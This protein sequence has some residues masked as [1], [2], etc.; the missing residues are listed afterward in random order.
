MFCFTL[1]YVTCWRLPF[2]STVI[3]D[4]SKKWNSSCPTFW[5]VGVSD[6]YPQRQSSPE[7]QQQWS[8]VETAKR[9]NLCLCSPDKRHIAVMLI[10]DGPLPAAK[11]EAAWCCH[12]A[13]KCLREGRVNTWV[14]CAVLMQWFAKLVSF[15]NLYRNHKGWVWWYSV[16]V[17]LSK[18]ALNKTNQQWT[19]T[20]TKYCFSKVWYILF[21]YAIELHCCP[22][23]IKNT[24]R[25]RIV[26]LDGISLHYHEH[27]H[28]VVYYDSVPHTLPCCPK[29]SL[30]HQMWIHLPQK[31]VPDRCI[32]SSCLSNV[33]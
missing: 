32:T 10:N 13:K 11:A 33:W 20:T 8:F 17:L 9:L 21:L 14:C 18:N 5:P 24:S 1:T 12:T 29:Y 30:E 7:K 3:A 15:S 16:F 19:F 22:K 4:E 6:F 23:T 26:G 31:I 27:T 28:T 25:S 2:L